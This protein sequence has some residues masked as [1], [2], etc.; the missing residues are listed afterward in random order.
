MMAVY[1]RHLK[2]LLAG[3]SI[4]L[5][6]FSAK[7][8]GRI[9]TLLEAGV[10]EQKRVGA[11]Q[12]ISVI[13]YRGL[14]KYCQKQYPSGLDAAIAGVSTRAEAVA[15]YRDA[16]RV[17]GTDREA[18]LIRVFSEREDLLKLNDISLPAK[19]WCDQAGIAG[20]QLRDGDKLE[21][22]GRI[23]LVENIDVFWAFEKLG[24]SVDIVYYTG[25][26]FSG[27]FLSCLVPNEHI[28]L[29][30]C[31]DYDPVGLD[32]YLRIKKKFG[33]AEFYIPANI[34]ELFKYSKK[35]LIQDN[36]AILARL[37]LSLD[38]AVKRIVRLI[39]Q[40]NGGV[41]QE[42]LLLKNLSH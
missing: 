23:A 34:A 35:D 27:R 5:T 32:E 11:G 36:Q 7:L 19:A 40:H 41:E 33:A 3:Q 15:V 30:H 9:K 42:I 29:L 4:P 22:S 37:R 18:L 10:L 28:S 1:A 6:K 20:L 38:E 16:K 25:G 24:V 13:S 2:M 26:R 12:S 21:I 39:D 8:R 17:Q 14:E 31:G